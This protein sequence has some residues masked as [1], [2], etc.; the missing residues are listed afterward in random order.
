MSELVPH[1]SERLLSLTSVDLLDSVQYASRLF[2]A[3]NIDEMISWLKNILQMIEL[4]YWSV[5][6]M[7]CFRLSPFLGRLK[8]LYKN[9][10]RSDVVPF[11]VIARLQLHFVILSLL[12]LF[13]YFVQLSSSFINDATDLHRGIKVNISN[14]I[15]IEGG[16]KVKIH[17]HCISLLERRNWWAE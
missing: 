10:T 11:V 13:T 9:S 1:Y 15:F 8:T 3:Q 12:L 16:K 14:N 4:N 6:S 17:I 7:K 5:I 2:S